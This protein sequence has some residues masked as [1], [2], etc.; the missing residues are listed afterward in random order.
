MRFQSKSIAVTDFCS[1]LFWVSS[2]FLF[3][4]LGAGSSNT[5]V[6]GG[7]FFL[8]SV[9][10]IHE[11]VAAWKNQCSELSFHQVVTEWLLLC[12]MPIL[13]EL[14]CKDFIYS[15]VEMLLI[16]TSKPAQLIGF[17]QR[18]WLRSDIQHGAGRGSK[19]LNTTL[20]AGDERLDKNVLVLLLIQLS[21]TGTSTYPLKPRTEQE[22]FFL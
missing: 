8:L 19:Q 12:N 13:Q 20:W 11:I 2:F 1:P 16:S 17:S 3:V 14:V 5:E 7:E 18:S 10:C 6:T 21:V 22:W 15:Y 9:S 4:L